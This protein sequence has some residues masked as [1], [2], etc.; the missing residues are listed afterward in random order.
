MVNSVFR[1]GGSRFNLSEPINRSR[2]H[3]S[4]PWVESRIR[5][6]NPRLEGRTAD[7]VPWTNVQTSRDP[8][9]ALAPAAVF[10]LG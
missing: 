7:A 2:F 6:F 9:V 10:M 4:G 1:A 5:R 3:D 8:W